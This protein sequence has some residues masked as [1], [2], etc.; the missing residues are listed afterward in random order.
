MNPGWEIRHQTFGWGELVTL[1]PAGIHVARFG[2]GVARYVKEDS[3][4]ER[5]P[6][7]GDV[8]AIPAPRPPATPQPAPAPTRRKL[9][10][11]KDE[12]KEL[13]G[14]GKEIEA[15]RKYSSNNA[16]QAFWPG[17]NYRK[18]KDDQRRSFSN[19]IREAAEKADVRRAKEIRECCNEWM[20]DSDFRDAVLQGLADGEHWSAM[21]DFATPDETGEVVKKALLQV[22]LA[23]DIESDGERIWEIGTATSASPDLL[24]SRDDGDEKLPAAL[25]VLA[26]QIQ[27]AKVMVGHNVLA[28]DWPII[29]RRIGS[30]PTPLI[31]DTL[32][33]QYL[34]EPQAVSHA[35]GGNHRAHDDAVASLRLFEKQLDL[36]RQPQAI[37]RRVLTGEFADAAQLLAEISV[38]SQGAVG[39][40][41]QLPDFLAA[42]GDDP[43][44]LMLVPESRLRDVDWV[45]GVTVLAAD[46]DV[47]LTHAW[48]QIDLELL[49]LAIQIVD[50][51]SPAAHVVLAVARRAAA[52]NIALRRNMIPFWLLEGDSRLE[53]AVDSA[54]VEPQKRKDLCIASL[55]TRADWWTTTDPSTYQIAGLR[56]DVLV[57]DRGWVASRDISPDKL[58][59]AANFMRHSDGGRVPLWLLRDRP[60]HILD[61]QGGLCSFRTLPIRATASRRDDSQRELRCRPIVATRRHHV[62]HSHAEDQAGYWT[63]MLRTFREV[64]AQGKD[65]VSILL[66]GS[67]CSKELI[68][69][70]ATGLA[71]LDFGEVK[72][73]HRSRRER[74]LR[75]ARNGHAL[76]D[77]LDQWPMW[78]SLAGSVGIVL[79]PVVEA[80]PI[81]EWYACAEAQPE[82]HADDSD[83]QTNRHPGIAG[84]PA[85]VDAAALLEKL[86]ALVDG[87]LQGWL[88]DVRLAESQTPVVF[89]D[90]RIS[91]IG[92]G[93]TRLADLLP[94]REKPL[95]DKHA[96]GLGNALSRFRLEREEAPSGYEAMESFLVTNFQ[97]R[98]GKRTFTGFKPSQRDAMEAI[99]G[100]D[101]HVL[102]S[103]PTGEGKSVLFQVPAL[104]RGLRNRR[105]TLV[106]SPLKALMRDQVERLREHGFAESADY[107]SGDRLPHEATEIIQGV[108]DHRIVLLYVAPERLRSEVFLDVLD[109]RMRTDG[110][111]EHVVFDEAHC[112]NQ[113]GYE[114]RPD[115]FHALDLL[116]RRCRTMDADNSTPFLLLSATI[117]ASDRARLQA[118]LSRESGEAGASLPLLARP[119]AFANPLRSHIAV[120]AHRVRGN[121]Y[122]RREFQN[123]LALRLP[124]IS[125]VIAEARQNRASTGQ[126]SAVLVFV[127]SRAHAEEVARR[128]ASDSDGRVDYYHAGLDAA[129][130]DDIY[131]RF[132]DGDLD[133]LVAT[134]A[135][136]MGMDIP[137][138]HGVVH[139]SPPGYLEDYL[140]EVGRI[141]R[142]PEARARARLD[143][144]SA[145]LLF[146]DEDFGALRSLRA[147]NALSFPFIKGLHQDVEVNAHEVDGQRVAIVPSEGYAPFKGSAAARRAAAT[148]VRMA[149]Y[150]LERAGRVELCGSIPDLITVTIHSSVLRKVSGQQGLAGQVAR[151]ILQAEAPGAVFDKA[152][153]SPEAVSTT[154]TDAS[155][156]R[157]DRD[158]EGGL[159]GGAM[160]LLGRLLSALADT[161]GVLLGGPTKSAR[162]P[163]GA[164]PRST[165]KPSFYADSSP[166]T[167]VLNVSQI[168]L[169]VGLLKSMGDVLACLA[170]LEKLGGLSLN[171]DIQ[172]VRR[173]LATEPNQTIM[174]F[175][176]Y[177]DGAADELI[178]RLT[179]TGRLEFNP[180]DMVEGV[181]G[182]VVEDNKRRLY[183]RAFINGFRSLARASGIKLRQVVRDD[184]KVIWEAILAPKACPR[185]DLRRAQIRKGSQSL[186]AVVHGKESIQVTTLIDTLRKSSPTGKF[187]EAD[188]KKM[189]GL[190]S[191]MCLVN[192]SSELIPLSHVVMLSDADSAL[193][194]E[195]GLW[196]E[197]KQINELAE[198]RNLAMEVFANMDARAHSTFIE[199]YFATL[200]AQG[201][202]QFLETQLGEIPTEDSEEESVSTVIAEMREKLRAT[203]AVE[204]FDKFKQSEEPN[205]WEVARYPFDGHVLVNAGPGAGKTFV[206][207]GRIVHLIRE[208]NIDPAQIVVLA[209]NRAVVFEIKRRIRELFKSLGYAAYASR[210]RVSTFHSF[211]IRN[212]ARID[213]AAIARPNLVGVLATFAD[214][215]E[216]D[217]AF[218]HNVASGVRCILVDEFQDMTDHVYSVIR[219]LYL[220]SDSRA[221]V[222]VIGDD[223]QDILRWQRT[224]GPTAHEFAGEYFEDFKR[225]FGGENLGQ[226]VL[227]TNFRSGRVIVE[228]SQALIA[229]HFERRTRSGRLKTLKLVPRKDVAEGSCER[230]DWS[231]RT[232]DEAIDEVARILQGL[233][234]RKV[235]STAILCRSN[236]EVSE[237]HR[238]LSGA[239]PHLSV[240]GA[241]NLPI[242]NL[243]HVGVWLDHLRGAASQ[244]DKALSDDLK[245]EL[246]HGFARSVAIPDFRGPNTTEI[247]LDSLWALCCREQAFPHLS[248][249]I[250]F[251]EDLQSDDL[252]RMS[253]LGSATSTAVVST[254]HKVK[255]LEFDNVIILPSSIPFRGNNLAGD[256]DEEAR[257]LYVG[258]TRAKRYL[259][260][261]DGDREFSWAKVVPYAGQNADGRVFVGSMKGEVDLGWA[262]RLQNFNQNPN[263]CQSYI[264]SK[265]AV[266]DPIT[267]GGVGAGANRAIMHGTLGNLRQVG[268]LK[269]GIGAGGPNASLKVSAVVRFHPDQIDNSTAA[270]VRARG[271]GYAVLVSGRLR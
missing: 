88:C 144:L 218:R 75:A 228:Q 32:L 205:Q 55:P 24:L 131:T 162:A 140:Q 235:E 65:T 63:E 171:R 123:A 89:I 10:A 126:R 242:A 114:F 231:D 215:M 58:P 61:P 259:T 213:G 12:L 14:T 80:L 102:V 60:A 133:V 76:V 111:L 141:G 223:D 211:A 241:A 258:M 173:D 17:A 240:Q 106:V 40:A 220:G 4:V 239:I 97:P 176:D 194:D 255:G 245:R 151:L 225:D 29:A 191:A 104:C 190:L 121:L 19:G 175:F 234:G 145:M 98:D 153:V 124:F 180:F 41:R 31:W 59:K 244:H 138:I 36:L 214:R 107:L 18:Y 112:V 222:M 201:L 77:V 73:D 54:C 3:I 260:Y 252:G 25:D 226:F 229:R 161:V 192:I 251:V 128:L 64:A 150:W 198:V 39:L 74:L 142:D 257:L 125:K 22:S 233:K 134:K 69:L 216:T 177:V 122:D 34:L 265:V 20:T 264:E 100:R 168:R 105:L 174:Q 238:R 135:F 209:F 136:G 113:W 147:H 108:L 224:M 163:T 254:L 99:C 115:Y 52:Q 262:Y 193:E 152:T 227:G 164:A 202:R 154:S 256:A 11:L 148:R 197:L 23:V 203:K 155:S 49:E 271:W 16:L 266:G 5:R 109:K 132:R 43:S 189:A 232:W 181:E 110:G 172:I 38:P 237:A 207:V 94:L 27:G 21:G 182:P 195:T 48:R 184:D 166:K 67:S 93:L 169:R 70:L 96:R 270:C 51:P 35:L 248:S 127:S 81:E 30:Q 137:D 71:E 160:N 47:D 204:F 186:F 208:Q 117:T 42:A 50:E 149:L 250:R 68:D 212:L 6:P 185:A 249:L 7:R 116:L 187:R 146:A 167:V 57:L 87:R 90:P 26:E 268:F 84:E 267:L 246:V 139:L 210:L 120:Q 101:V 53:A 199:G 86:P 269:A 103:L 92:K 179:G 165:P 196:N 2:N 143:Q 183:E 13:L 129:A 156:G 72:P 130:R 85:V 159:L 91:V 56:D 83:E 188:M 157:N 95:S 236:A 79:R 9:Q 46:P 200:E 62:L 170:D 158:T 1:G 263:A 37:A 82:P 230:F 219:N 28:W 243:R 247:R 217:L 45:P 178:R 15:D 118:V 44:R 78:Q 8:A 206:L 221:G 261:F 253:G 66:V 119:D 33:V